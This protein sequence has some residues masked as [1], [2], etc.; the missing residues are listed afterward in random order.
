MAPSF[1][2]EK[3]SRDEAI[4]LLSFEDVVLPRAQG[5]LDALHLYSQHPQLLSRESLREK[6]FREVAQ[7]NVFEVIKRIGATWIFNSQTGLADPAEFASL[8]EVERQR[9]SLTDLIEDFWEWPLKEFASSLILDESLLKKLQE[10]Q[11]EYAV[12]KDIHIRMQQVLLLSSSSF[13]FFL[14][15]SSSSSSDRKSV[16]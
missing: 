11:Q 16:V 10:L 14:L 12:Y 3:I 5:G 15:L 6:L 8:F 9:E 13:F 1:L 4:W 7:G 2:A